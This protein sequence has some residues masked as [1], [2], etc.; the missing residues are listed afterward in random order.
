ME[1]EGLPQGVLNI[2]GERINPAKDESVLAV[3]G[4]MNSPVDALYASYPS[5][6]V[7]VY[8]GKLAGVIQFTVTV[9]YTDSTK[10]SITSA[11]RT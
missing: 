9:T 11:V 4:I 3:A 8:I 6:T 7:E 5:S 1:S 10:T 2:D